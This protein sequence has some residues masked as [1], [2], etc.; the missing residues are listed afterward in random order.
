MNTKSIFGLL[1]F[2]SYPFILQALPLTLLL[3]EVGMWLLFLLIILWIYFV[4]KRTIGSIGWKKLTSRMVIGA[5]G[6]GVVMFLFLGIGTTAIRAIGLELNQ[7]MA[8]LFA[9]QPVFVLF[10]IALRAAVVEEVLYRGYAFERIYE[11]TQ[12]KL[13]A[14]LAPLIL[15]MLVHL[16]WGLG[17]LLFV[18]LAGGL[19]TLVY[20]KK[21]NLAIVIIAHFSADVIALIALPM[22]IG[23]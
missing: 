2:L 14:G 8:K 6:L 5:I 7:D 10:L 9:S 19:L 22:L 12:S 15:F 17:H 20:A 1:I 4:E 21:R 23:N 13:F 11:L 18:F 16:N 3:G